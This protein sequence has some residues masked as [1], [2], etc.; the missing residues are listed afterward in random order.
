MILS[1]KHRRIAAKTD[2][3]IVVYNY[4]TKK[5]EPV[6]EFVRNVLRD[7][8]K[9]QSDEVQ[10]ACARIRELTAQVE[11][12]EKETWNREDAVE[13]M[14]SADNNDEWDIEEAH[15]AL[16]DLRKTANEKKAAIRAEKEGRK[17]AKLERRR[18][19]KEAKKAKETK[20]LESFEW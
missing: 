10:R 9:Q 15:R 11:G 20:D 8:W 16:Q 4:D 12:L 7:T 2:E 19:F 18:L 14:G 6:P 3:D 5:K 1:H 17:Q 13:D